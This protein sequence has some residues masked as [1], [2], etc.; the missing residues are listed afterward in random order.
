MIGNKIADKITSISK[1]FF[2]ELQNEEEIEIP[3]ERYI[4]LEKKNQLFMN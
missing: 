1:N 4:S 2:S 3:K